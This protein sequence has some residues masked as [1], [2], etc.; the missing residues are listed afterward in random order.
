MLDR[1]TLPVDELTRIAANSA[2]ARLRIAPMGYIKGMAVMFAVAQRKLAQGDP[3]ALEMAKP[4]SGDT[5]RDALAHYASRF[6]RLG[7]R[8]DLGGIETLR[9]LFVLMFGLGLRESSG[10]YC[11]GF[12]RERN[13]DPLTSESAEAGLFQ[14]SWNARSM[15]PFIPQL[16]DDYKRTGNGYKPIFAEGVTPT[17]RDLEIVGSGDGAAF[18]RMCKEMPGLAVETAAVGLRKNGGATGHWGPIRRHEAELRPE[19]D[20]MLRQVQ[21]LISMASADGN[22]SV[23]VPVPPAPVRDIMWVQQSLNTLGAD[24]RL[25]EDGENGPLTMAAVAQ[26]QRTNG[27]NESGFADSATVAAMERKL[28]SI[29]S[30]GGGQI[31]PAPADILVWLERLVTLIEKLQGQ[32][33]APGPSP[34]PQQAEQFRKAIELLTAI[35][36]PGNDGKSQPLGQVNGALGETL[37][38]LLNGNKTAIGLLGAV[39]TSVLHQVPSGTGLGDVI[40]MLTPATGLSGYTMPVF[41]GLAAWGVLGKFEKWAQGTAPPPRPPS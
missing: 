41:L 34:G 7:M 37:G 20:D 27:L 4:V 8:N 12:D 40:A 31:P 18:Q 26:F 39:L 36:A 16:C 19:A 15:S 17:S 1:L 10:R 3:A 2:L 24:P 33:T 35:L 23:D 28:R 32:R 9:H 38:N 11:E 25:D 22:I 30:T 21:S 6:A 29:T 5:N 13:R 14:M